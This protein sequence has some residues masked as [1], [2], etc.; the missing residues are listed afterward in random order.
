MHAH[1]HAYTLPCMSVFCMWQRSLW[2]HTYTHTH[3]QCKTRDTHTKETHRQIWKSYSRTSSNIMYVCMCA[4]ALHHVH[5]QRSVCVCI[6]VS[7]WLAAVNKVADVHSMADN[8]NQHTQNK[9]LL[10]SNTNQDC[11]MADP[12]INSACSAATSLQQV[13]WWRLVP[14]WLRVVICALSTCLGLWSFVRWTFLANFLVHLC[15]ITWCHANG[16]RPWAWSFLA[17]FL[18]LSNS[19]CLQKWHFLGSRFLMLAQQMLRRWHAS[20]MWAKIC[21]SLKHIRSKLFMCLSQ[22]IFLLLQLIALG[23]PPLSLLESFLLAW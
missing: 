4:C 20:W 8:S 16:K 18:F 21:F 17:T 3:R 2:R 11:S 23:F 13:E 9:C 19:Q 5:V 10:W 1:T 12:C 15:S 22:S 7:M 6:Y 14:I